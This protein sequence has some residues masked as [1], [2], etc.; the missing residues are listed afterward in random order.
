MTMVVLGRFSVCELS[1]KMFARREL[2]PRLRLWVSRS[3]RRSYRLRYVRRSRTAEPTVEFSALTMVMVRTVGAWLAHGVLVVPP[4][5][6]ASVMTKV[7][8]FEAGEEDGRDDEH[9]AGDDHNPCCESVEPIWF[10]RHGRWLG[11]DGGRPG[12]DFRCFAHI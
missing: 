8:D 1:R 2:H 11:G 9:D 12:W 6:M 4:V 7:G 10:V 5:V 3:E